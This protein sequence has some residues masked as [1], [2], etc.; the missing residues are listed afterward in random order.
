MGLA[1]IGLLAGLIW[2]NNLTSYPGAE[3]QAAPGF[4]FR[5]QPT[6]GLNQQIAYQT[7]DDMPKVLS[8]YA[9]HFGLGHETP[10]GNNCVAMTQ[11]DTRLFLQQ[12]LTVTLC[13][14]PTRTLIFIDRSLTVR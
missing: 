3:R 13:A 10:Q 11:V 1:V 5:I 2:G 7:S 9:Q 6:G 8:W 14:H 4:E 12:S